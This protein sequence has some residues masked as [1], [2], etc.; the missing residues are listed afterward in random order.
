[1]AKI[2]AIKP[3]SYGS[4]QWLL[5]E[6]GRTLGVGPNP[7]S[8]AHDQLRRVDSIVQSGV[9]QFYFC[10]PMQ[11]DNLDGDSEEVRD[12]RLR[13]PHTW[14]FLNQLGT[15]ELQPGVSL[16]EL[17][18]DFAGVNGDLILTNGKG[19]IPVVAET[20]LR[21]IAAS[22]ASTGDPQYAAVRPKTTKGQSHQRWEVLLYP[23]PTDIVSVNYRYTVAQSDLSEEN[24][25]PLGGI[26]HAETALASCLAVAEDRESPDS[27]K[28]RQLFSQRLAASIHI[29]KR[30]AKAAAGTTWDADAVDTVSR[31][32]GL[33]GLHMG[34]G[35]NS[36]AWDQTALQMIL[37]AMRQGVQRFYVP[38][39]IAG[40][41][42]AHQWSF[43]KPIA[44]INLSSGKFQY[45]LPKDYG[46]L[47]SPITYAPG[48]N[49]IYPPIDVIGEH[50]IRRLQQASTQADGRPTRAGVRQKAGVQESGTQYEILLWPVPDASYEL[51]YRYRVTPGYDMSV[52]HGGDAHFQTILEAMKA[53]ADTML[54][55]KQRPHEQLFMERLTASVLL[56]EQ[57]ASPKQMGYNRDGSNRLGYDIFDD[58]HRFGYGESSVGYNGIN[59]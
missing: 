31:L 13:Q 15:F 44:T 27:T 11:Q 47:D 55:R 12:N 54:K 42:V 28:S 48:Q 7:Q 2:N 16:Y 32:K 49:V 1:M 50:H 18:E 14:S 58:N 38:P 59:Y 23:T 5:R 30:V 25:F 6:V 10:P 39:P 46:G 45:D 52:I 22:D 43:L 19:R 29:D 56:D 36:A 51:Q 8:Y 40:R 3:E 33:V 34:Y 41:R 35:Q 57:L 20:H 37:E 53:S 17:P 21:Q 24:P 4:Y 26:A 9:M